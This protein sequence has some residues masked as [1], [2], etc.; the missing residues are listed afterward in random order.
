MRI[1]TILD[2]RVKY[3]TEKTGRKAINNASCRF[4]ISNRSFIR[5]DTPNGLLAVRRERLK[6]RKREREKK[7]KERMKRMAV[8]SVENKET[9][10]NGN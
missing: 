2:F 8:G 9:E 3:F 10:K 6:E 4:K 1:R 5:E 7:A